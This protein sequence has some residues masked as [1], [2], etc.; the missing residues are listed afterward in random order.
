MNGRAMFKFVMDYIPADIKIILKR[1]SYSIGDI[2]KFVFHQA[3]R[4]IVDNLAGSLK[5]D[6]K[7]VVFDIYEYGNTVSSSIPLILEKEIKDENNRNILISGFGVGLSWS[8]GIL[9]RV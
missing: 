3:S 8:S 1:N 6:D 5:I 9:K 7:R 2:D 4:F